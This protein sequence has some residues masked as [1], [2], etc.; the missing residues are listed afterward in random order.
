V[1]A[2]RERAPRHDA[3]NSYR[4]VAVLLNGDQQA[5]PEDAARWVAQLCRDLSIRPLRDHGLSAAHI[6]DLVE[7]AV[8]ASSMKGN[9]LVLTEAELSSLV[10]DAL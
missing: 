4:R 3:L 8:K 10:K 6:P 1:A 9:P 5:E 7:K 2:L